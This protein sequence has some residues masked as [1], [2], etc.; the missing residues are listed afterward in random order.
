MK[1]NTEYS[2]FIELELYQIKFVH[3]KIY[4]KTNRMF[5]AMCYT[6]FGSSPMKKTKKNPRETDKFPCKGS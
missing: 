2:K 1:I 4:T 5:V 6:Y 3:I